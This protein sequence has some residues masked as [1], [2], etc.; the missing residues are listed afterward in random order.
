MCTAISS[1]RVR[2]K[3]TNVSA[4]EWIL[5]VALGAIYVA[6]IVT[7]A[8]Y[9]Y[10]KG[11]MLLFWLGF[12]LPFLWMIGAIIRPKPGSEFERREREYWAQRGG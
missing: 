6:L 10:R 5:I 9:T 1:R 3:G 2:Q 4:T 7:L 8:T 11:H 12:L